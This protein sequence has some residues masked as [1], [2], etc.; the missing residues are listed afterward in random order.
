MMI[1]SLVAAKRGLADDGL[2]VGDKLSIDGRTP[3]EELEACREVVLEQTARVRNVV[4]QV[5]RP[6]MAEEGLPVRDWAD[7][8]KK[9]RAA[10][11]AYYE[12]SVLPVLTSQEDH[13]PV[14]RPKHN[15]S[16]IVL[17][18]IANSCS[19]FDTL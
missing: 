17:V 7:V 4:S 5:L 13:S 3:A 15:P 10:L 12:R 8:G 1:G 16:V 2:R 6:A 18:Y 9:D 19:D 11:R 14:I